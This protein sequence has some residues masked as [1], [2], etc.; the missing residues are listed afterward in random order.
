MSLRSYQWPRLV[1]LKPN[2]S[3]LEAARALDN[4]QVGAIVVQHEGRV[5]GIVTDRDLAVRVL[6]QGLDARNTT[7]AKVMTEDVV[8]LPPDGSRTDALRLMQERRIRRIP[9]VAEGAVVG[10][11]TLDDLLADEAASLED[12]ADVVRAQVGDGGPMAPTRLEMQAARRRASRLDA[13]YRRFVNEFRTEST[14]PSVDQADTALAIVLSALVR[15]LTA[16]EAK[17]L[18]AQLPLRIGERLRGLPPGP[19]KSI[20]A[21]GILAELSERLGVASARASDVLDAVVRT[22]DANVSAGQMQD[23]RHQLP[24]DLRSVFAPAER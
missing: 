18:I 12:F 7:L 24:K 15:R 5:A 20:T 16:D 9:L 22:L 4:N 2:T 13:S 17:D 8:T 19:D 23:V 14:L 10:V 21:E 1:I 6:G 11:V 3:V